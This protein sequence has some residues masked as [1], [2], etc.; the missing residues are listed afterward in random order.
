MKKI[1]YIF[2]FVFYFTFPS[3]GAEINYFQKGKNLFTE[4]KYDQAKFKFEQDL[5]FNPKNENSYL[6]LAK[7]F[8]LKNDDNQEESNLKTVILLNPKNEEAI[9]NLALLK[10]RK[11]NYSETKK[12]LDNFKKNCQNMC[13]KSD[14]LRDKL[15]SITKK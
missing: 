2:I 14:E 8:K 10:I 5:V 1:N 6:Y 11:S 15:S 12:L 13:Q 9:Y 4:K 7:I 3:L